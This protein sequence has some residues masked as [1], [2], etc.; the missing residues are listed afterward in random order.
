MAKAFYPFSLQYHNRDA[1]TSAPPTRRI[2]IGAASP[3]I[4]RGDP[5]QCEGG[6]AAAYV[7]GEGVFGIANFTF[8]AYDAAAG[9]KDGD[10]A[11]NFGLT[12]PV[13]GETVAYRVQAR[14]M[15]SQVAAPVLQ[16]VL[17][18]A[19]NLAGLTGV[20]Y[21]D[22]SAPGTDFLVIDIEQTESAWGDLYPILIV[23]CVNPQFEDPSLPV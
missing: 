14:N 10:P 20:M 2:P 7:P 21:L 12:N 23:Q 6:V 8:H 17:G 5:V 19:Y 22:V 1:G 11:A 16:T 3:V 15:D 9:Q 4:S 13:N 18:N